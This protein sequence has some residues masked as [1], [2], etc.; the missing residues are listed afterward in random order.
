MCSNC[1]LFSVSATKKMKIYFIY[2]HNIN[3]K[4]F[5]GKFFNYFDYFKSIKTGIVYDKLDFVIKLQ[6]VLY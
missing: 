2:L 3:K 6:K 5:L 1:N 4:W